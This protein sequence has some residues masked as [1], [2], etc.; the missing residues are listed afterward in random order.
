MT[1]RKILLPILLAFIVCQY[2]TAQQQYYS[3]IT[4]R[5]FRAPDDLIGY[6][7][8]PS[9]MQ[10][11][12]GRPQPIAA[13]SY[14][15][16][17]SNNNLYV[18]GGDLKGIYSVNSINPTEYGFILSLMNVRDPMIQGHLKVVL[19][20]LA[21][22]E[23]LIFKKDTKAEEIIFFLPKKSEKYANQETAYFTNREAIK[24][25]D[26]DALWGN[27]LRPLFKMG[28]HQQRLQIADSLE[29]SLVETW[30]VEDKR[31][32]PKAKKGEELPVLQDL[33]K[34]SRGEVENM[35]AEDKGIK[36]ILENALRLRELVPQENGSAQEK[37]ELFPVAGLQERE[38]TEAAPDGERYQIALKINKSGLKEAY[39]YLTP[40]RTISSVEIGNHVYWMSGR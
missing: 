4:D 17:I 9:E 21:Q 34:L 33:S 30:R 8:H 18:D 39:I 15:F 22:A 27:T 6:D 29:I 28:D 14:S 23:A 11:K 7:F 12:G 1:M 10:P 25:E 40:R 24:I 16:G 36:I 19:N 13:G 38:D 32:K 2:A 35:A 26:L 3:Y 5:S 20:K 31:K 37:V